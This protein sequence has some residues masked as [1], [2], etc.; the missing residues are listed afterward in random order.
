[1]L[2][3]PDLELAFVWNRTRAPLLDEASP[4]PADLVLDDLD[5]CAEA[6]PDLIVE[7]A[8]PVV[9]EK[10]FNAVFFGKNGM[11]GLLFYSTEPSSF[12]YAT[13]WSDL[14][15]LWPTGKNIF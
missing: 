11:S 6:R 7:V 4:V 5:R 13:S 8:H 15:Q 3:S 14:P 1:M 9:T 2:D 12:R 10:V